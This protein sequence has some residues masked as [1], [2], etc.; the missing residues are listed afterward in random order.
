MLA[1]NGSHLSGQLNAKDVVMENVLLSYVKS[2]WNGKHGMTLCVIPDDSFTHFSLSCFACSL[3]LLM[4][5]LHSS[6]CRSVSAVFNTNNNTAT[7]GLATW[8]SNK[9]VKRNDMRY[10]DSMLTKE[11]KV[12]SWH[13]WLLLWSC[14]LK[15]LL[16]MTWAE[17]RNCCSGDCSN[18]CVNPQVVCYFL[19][20]FCPDDW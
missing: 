4:I 7:T 2:L 9:S 8:F 13:S 16:R 18:K 6:L 19:I 5:S 15:A 14:F 11:D 20:L 3:Q 10:R 12:W 1:A 17:K